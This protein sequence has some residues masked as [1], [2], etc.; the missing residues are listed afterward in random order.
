[1]TGGSWVDF[2]VDWAEFSFESAFLSTDLSHFRFSCCLF[3]F[4]NGSISA[5]MLCSKE[6][7]LLTLTGEAEPC[8]PPA[9][10]GLPGTLHD[11]GVS[12][13]GHRAGR[14]PL[15]GG[16]VLPLLSSLQPCQAGPHWAW[17]IVLRRART[18][19][20]VHSPAQMNTKMMF[21]FSRCVLVNMI[22]VAF[23]KLVILL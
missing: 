12:L 3:S 15:C 2:S 22:F 20:L 11:A 6:S 14:V 9:S 23:C 1:M 5:W 21:L 10:M 13:G 7:L 19:I 4:R 18:R 17:A 8:F 16:S